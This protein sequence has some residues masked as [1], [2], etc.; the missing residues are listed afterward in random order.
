MSEVLCFDVYGSTHNQHSIVD[1][2][3]AVTGLPT[4]L[5]ADL[6]RLWVDH[7]IGY[8]MEVSLMGAYE[9]WYDL[10]VRS[11][12]Y[13]LEYYGVEP[14]EEVVET[15]MAAYEHLEPYEDLSHFGRLQEAGHDLYIL[16][17]GT[18]E[19]LRTLAGNTGFDAYVDGIASV[20]EAG[21]YKPHP[22]AYRTIEDHVDR[23]LEE[24]TMVATHTFDVAGASA[25]GMETALVNRFDVPPTRLGHEPGLV[26]DS[27][28]ELADEL[29]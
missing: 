28:A 29:S 6:S 8:S 3:A 4:D 27:Y 21:V 5:A 16:S 19:M 14:T 18:P 26:V 1:E 12:R 7:Q 15:L 22:D 13:A 17:D 9:D 25:A 24:C 20:D 11:L 2:I 23:P 10:T